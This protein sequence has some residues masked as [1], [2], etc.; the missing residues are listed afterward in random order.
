MITKFTKIINGLASLGDEIDNGQKV[1]KVIRAVL[2]SWEVKFT[3]LKELNN[4]E[5]M[6]LIGLIGNLKTHEIEWK[7]REEKK[8]KKKED[9]CLQIYSFHLWWR[10]W[11][12]PFPPCEECKDDVQQD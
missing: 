4:K 12:R 10:R 8:F 9:S 5:E 3:T 7:A 1:R 6:K 11:W 2:P